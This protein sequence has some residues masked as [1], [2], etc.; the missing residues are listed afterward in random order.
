MATRICIEAHRW[1]GIAAALAACEPGDI[2]QIEP[3]TYAG[4]AALNVGTGV[5][6]RGTA[7][8][9]LEHHGAGPAIWLHEA[10]DAVVRDL[11]IRVKT[12]DMPVRT[13]PDAKVEEQAPSKATS[14]TVVEWG[15]VFVSECERVRIEHVSIRGENQPVHG[16]A[17]RQSGDVHVSACKAH[18]MG[19]N[20]ITFASSSGSVTSCDLSASHHGISA[21]PSGAT[22]SPHPRVRIVGNRCHDNEGA[23]IRLNS[24]QSD[25]IEANACWANKDSG[26]LLLR[27]PDT[28]NA[29]SVAR[30]VGNRCHDNEQ[31]GIALFSSQSDAIEANECCANKASG[32]ALDRD[33]RAPDA[34]SVARIVGNRCHD[35]EQAGI[36]L[37]SSQS[38]AIEA[39]E[40]CAN[41]ASGILLQRDPNR[42]DAPSVAR[43]VANRCHDNEQ[44]GIALLSSQSDAIEANKCWANKAS[45]I[46]LDRDSRAPDASSV[47]RIVANRCHD[48]EQ[49]GIA[50]FSSQ[51]DTIEESECWANKASGILL[52]RD[53]NRPDAPSVARIVANRCHDNE[54]AGIALLSSQS[55]AIEA[56]KCWANKASG[57]LLQRDPNR[58][59]APSV[60]RI[61]ANRCHDNE[62]AGIALFSSQSDTIEESECWANKASGIAL[63]RD[64]RAPDAP[65]VARIVAN[66]CHDNEEA[67]IALQ[68][69]QSD[70]I[71]ANKCWANKASGILLQ[72][73]PNRLDAPSV[74][75]IVANRCHDNEQAGIALFSSQSDTIEE[76]ECWANKASGIAL[77]RD[78]RA[79]D[80]PSVARI[81]AN[82]CH[83]NEEAGIAL[84]SSQSDAIEANECWA[85]KASGITLHRD[86]RT[87]DAPSVACI[88]ANRCHHNEQDGIALF[89][90]QSDA[91]EANECWANKRFGIGLMRD[92]NSLAE[93]SVAR[94]VTNRC[95]GNGEG[96]VFASSSGTAESNA[97]WGNASG[98]LV[99]QVRQAE[100]P[101]EPSGVEVIDHRT[102]PSMPPEALRASRRSQARGGA[103]ADRLEREGVDDPD[104]LAELV[105]GPGCLGCLVRS[106]PA[107]RGTEAPPAAPVLL[108]AHPGRWLTVEASEDRRSLRLVP[109]CDADTQSLADVFWDLLRETALK[110]K[111]QCVFVGVVSGST[112]P[113]AELG[114]HVAK[115]A[116]ALGDSQMELPEL[117]ERHLDTLDRA[118]ARG[119]RVAPAVVVDQMERSLNFLRGAPDPFA[120]LEEALTGSSTLARERWRAAGT[121]A[122]Q[123]G[124]ATLALAAAF[125]TA[126]S[127]V[128]GK[129]GSWQYVW[130]LGSYSALDYAVIV[131]LPSALLT[132]MWTWLNSL[133]PRS[134][135]LKRWERSLRVVDAMRRRLGLSAPDRAEAAGAPQQ[136]S[137][138]KNQIER[139]LSPGWERWV[140]QRL[141][142]PGTRLAVLCI[143]DADLWSPVDIAALRRIVAMRRASQSLLIV[144]QARDR[145]LVHSGLLTPWVEHNEQSGAL[146][147]HIRHFDSARLLLL[148]DDQRIDVASLAHDSSQASTGE[149]DAA[150]ANL[151]GWPQDSRIAGHAAALADSRWSVYDLA[152]M[153]V[154]GSTAH[155]AFE[156]SMSQ[157]DDPRQRMPMLAETLRP[158]TEL[159]DAG[160]L[161]QEDAPALAALGREAEHAAGILVAP[162]GNLLAP[163]GMQ[164]LLGRSGHRRELA[165]ALR[166]LFPRGDAGAARYT[167]Y[168][169]RLI[170][171]GELFHL[172]AAA[173]LAEALALDQAVLSAP[174]DEAGRH[175]VRARRHV[176]AARM[177]HAERAALQLEQPAEWRL[178]RAW[179]ALDASCAQLD[180]STQ[181]RLHRQAARL[182]AAL[183]HAVDVLDPATRGAGA[184]ADLRAELAKEWGEMEGHGWREGS[185]AWCLVEWIRACLAD[186]HGLDVDLADRRLR[187]LIADD[188]RSFPAWL[189]ERI[190]T[191]RARDI[192]GCEAEP[193][194]AE[195]IAR[196]ES[197]ERLIEVLTRHGELADLATGVM[198]WLTLRQL[199]DAGLAP[200]LHLERAFAVARGLDLGRRHYVP[201]ASAEAIKHALR[202]CQGEFAASLADAVQTEAVWR[203]LKAADLSAASRRP[204]ELDG[205][206]L[207]ALDPLR[208]ARQ[209]LDE[210]WHLG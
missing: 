135:R 54:Q 65:S 91:I 58:P 210:L 206:I 95:Y 52:Q 194:L 96:I 163:D 59:D 35:N 14:E 76:S 162:K 10:T 74:A 34:P 2:V 203:A 72:R 169:G 24:S 138:L 111:G 109:T 25:A 189:I 202:Y 182:Q 78:S 142:A 205:V 86:S 190:R 110:A 66:R 100:T 41:K 97:S 195:L 164:R 12:R 146:E 20:G 49:A 143:R 177:L 201:I 16:V 17:S 158:Y 84:Q 75:R 171:C 134:L 70:A 47:A 43:I 185:P 102:A 89:S 22:R 61:V 123:L 11:T 36:A 51:S 154:L 105:A 168:T 176:D 85:N 126:V 150:L 193:R 155:A 130:D 6:L 173:R 101:D 131:G 165:R 181:P 107:Q 144:I 69:S 8:T 122:V 188:W 153:L 117:A 79:P 149:P 53:P 67:G 48:N 120:L 4:S 13:V 77:H 81:V 92:S 1:E 132:G 90:S 187:D 200:E 9:V 204:P 103:V 32:I 192:A 42:P 21:F 104:A 160:R 199:R 94:L 37:F 196:S 125:L 63:H 198:C 178:V 68:S 175:L 183:L 148:D 19:R 115:A 23:G 151:L 55:D 127:Y 137:E 113:A 172:D 99:A 83:D 33:S 71:E 157:S 106:W 46:A 209:A 15:I 207:G 121:P 31:A 44:A 119:V 98:D 166:S 5:T 136:S 56:N 167:A 147:L 174:D 118:R 208:R 114:A 197:E 40:C 3:G 29:P 87:P 156:I 64:S 140:R 30:I 108:G 191:E 26:I 180:L 57:I 133:L 45:G 129:G 62:Q 112:D 7:D 73:D 152:P 159:C 93:R 60:A 139:L 145:S 141:F 82:R 27:G 186:L 116:A 124:M 170:A 28:P 184:T 88:V 80:A 128:K 50:L 161:G 179:E 38:D 39:N 18:A